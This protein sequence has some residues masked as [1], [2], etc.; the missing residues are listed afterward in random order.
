MLFRS[1]AA[2]YPGLAKV[3]FLEGTRSKKDQR[4]R[5]DTLQRL[6]K[7]PNIDR[8]ELPRATCAGEAFLGYY[9]QERY[10]VYN[11]KEFSKFH[12][13]TAMEA[14][15][16]NC[17]FSTATKP[18]W[19]ERGRR[20]LGATGEAQGIGTLLFGRYKGGS[21]SHDTCNSARDGHGNV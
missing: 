5:D 13:G 3:D 15:G 20:F 18:H 21:E 6:E 1:H 16:V 11:E 2:A 7:V 8:Y 12:G 17:N 19:R 4:E 9:V 14:A 10:N